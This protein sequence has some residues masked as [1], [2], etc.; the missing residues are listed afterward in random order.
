MPEILHRPSFDEFFGADDDGAALF[1]IVVRTFGYHEQRHTTATR[2]PF[3]HLT[4]NALGDVGRR[5]F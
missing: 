5:F 2:C 4:M 3:A 1:S